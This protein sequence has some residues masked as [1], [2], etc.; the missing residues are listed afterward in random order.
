VE[1]VTREG[2]ACVL[3]TTRRGSSFRNENQITSPKEKLFGGEACGNPLE[4]WGKKKEVR[5]EK[6]VEK[7]FHL[8]SK[9]GAWSLKGGKNYLHNIRLDGDGKK[10]EGFCSKRTPSHVALCTRTSS[11]RNRGNS[12]SKEKGQSLSQ[13]GRV[14]R[15]NNRSRLRLGQTFSKKRGGFFYLGKG[16]L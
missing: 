4:T 11:K 12:G 6:A 1:E 2:N 10:E 16:L 14:G 9:G 3:Q 15:N 7:N 5:R 13:K 8:T